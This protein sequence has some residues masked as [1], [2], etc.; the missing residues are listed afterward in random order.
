ME[1]EETVQSAPSGPITPE[2]KGI[3]IDGIKYSYSIVKSEKEEESLI[4]KLYDPNEKSDKYFTYE[5]PIHKLNND[6]KFLSLC[7]NIDEMV[8]SLNEVF[9]QGNAKVEE[10]HGEY[11][12]EFKV[13]GFGIKKKCF[14]RLT[15]HEIEQAKKPLNESEVTINKIE[16]KINDLYN[17][18]ESLRTQKENIIKEEN[19]RN[20]VK[21]VI[22]DKNIKNKLFEYPLPTIT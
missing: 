20:I 22:L 14:I 12:M 19:I 3:F 16:N 6:I 5:A 21:E 18:F 17:K 13:S 11:N 8:D 1:K 9:S 2:E 4:I 10:D 15:K 7:E